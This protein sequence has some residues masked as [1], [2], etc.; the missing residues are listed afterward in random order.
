VSAKATSTQK[1]LTVIE[2]LESNSES[3]SEAVLSSGNHDVDM[4]IRSQWQHK[5][6][7]N[8]GIVQW[9]F[10]NLI[11]QFLGVSL[12]QL[13][14]N[15]AQSPAGFW[16]EVS[17]IFQARSQNALWVYFILLSRFVFY[18]KAVI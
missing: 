12:E 1:T 18:L 17:S 10:R 6:V 7:N 16:Q 9:F 4:W 3:E 2:L 14:P 11:H 8:L 5:L 13:S 15:A